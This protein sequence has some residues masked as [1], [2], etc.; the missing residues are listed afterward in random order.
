MSSKSFM[1]FTIAA[2]CVVK[3]LITFS[4]KSWRWFVSSGDIACGAKRII[5]NLRWHGA[6]LKGCR[7]IIRW[8]LNA[9]I[10]AQYE[11]WIFSS[12][13]GGCNNI[14]CYGIRKCHHIVLAVGTCF[15]LID[16]HGER[17]LR[18][19]N[20]IWTLATAGIFATPPYIWHGN[21]NLTMNQ[22]TQQERL[23]HFL[24]DIF[25]NKSFWG[26]AMNVL[27]SSWTETRFIITVCSSRY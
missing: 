11:C 5:I 18:F 9:N 25:K 2:C 10:R 27:Q 17:P 26:G 22:A 23:S 19:E 1:S 20:V 7:L 6:P 16:V 12:W 3:R 21:S 15:V 13:Q 24:G 4:L 14:W 8:S